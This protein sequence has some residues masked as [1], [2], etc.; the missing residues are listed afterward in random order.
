MNI[1]I[2]FQEIGF[3]EICTQENKNIWSHFDE[4]GGQKMPWFVAITCGKKKKNIAYR[5]TLQWK[6]KYFLFYQIAQKKNN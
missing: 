2:V 3:R 4:K 5:K 6:E 1:Y